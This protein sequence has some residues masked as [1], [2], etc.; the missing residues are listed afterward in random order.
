MSV[1]IVA[2]AISLLM[3]SS[4]F[5]QARERIVQDNLGLGD[6]ELPRHSCYRV[7][8]VPALYL[9]N[10]RGKLVKPERV[11]WVGEVRDGARVYRR[12]IPATYLETRVLLEEDHYSLRRIP[13]LD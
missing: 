8:Y 3:L 6:R 12:R 4:G 10:T 5:G 13:C 1:R 2:A 7:I 9:V 11:V